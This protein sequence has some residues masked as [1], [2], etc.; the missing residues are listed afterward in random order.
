MYNPSTGCTGTNCVTFPGSGAST[1]VS[2]LMLS[3]ATNLNCGGCVNISQFNG[4]DFAPAATG[5]YGLSNVGTTSSYSGP[6]FLSAGTACAASTPPSPAPTSM[7]SPPPSSFT[8]YQVVFSHNCTYHGLWEITSSSQCSAAA[9]ALPQIVDTSPF[10]PPGG[11]HTGGTGWD[12]PLNCVASGWFAPSTQAGYL[13]YNTCPYSPAPCG[14]LYGLNSNGVPGYWGCLCGALDWAPPPSPS[15]SPPPPPAPPLYADNFVPYVGYTGP[16]TQVSGMVGPIVTS[17]SAETQLISTQDASY[18]LSFVDPQCSGGAGPAPNSCGVHIHTGTSCTAGAGGHYFANPPVTTDPW[19]SISYTS[20]MEMVPVGG[21]ESY[22]YGEPTMAVASVA[23][24]VFTVATGG[25]ASDVLGRTVIV[26]DFGGA[27]IACAV[28]AEGDPFAYPPFPPMDAGL[29]LGT[30]TMAA[31]SLAAIFAF[32]VLGTL[33]SKVCVASSQDPLLAW[34]GAA[35]PPSVEITPPAP[36]RA[37]L[38]SAGV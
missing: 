11:C 3:F 19:V 10:T 1:L 34:Q 14:A 9:A 16:L 28:I 7:A 22:A 21:A 27:R 31:I 35:P 2:Q 17:L 24:G 38:R 33:V 36:D 5:Y 29:A 26:H 13:G 37:S 6:Y 23:D 32:V 15:A 18:Q 4:V 20:R 25:P 30:G 12:R 8:A